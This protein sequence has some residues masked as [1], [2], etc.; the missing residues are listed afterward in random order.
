VQEGLDGRKGRPP[1]QGIAFFDCYRPAHLGFHK[2]ME[3]RHIRYFLRAVELMHFTR[4]AESLYVSQPS[5]SI[6]IRQLEEEFGA[7]LFERCRQLRLTEAGQLLFAHARA[8]VLELERAK[9]QIADLQG[10]LRGT[11]SIGFTHLFSKKLVPAVLAAYHEAHPNISLIAE[12][13]SS[14]EVEHDILTGSIDVGLAYLPPESNEIEYE[15]L[16]SDKVFLAVSHRHPFAK[17][18]EISKAELSKLPLVLQS[19]GNTMRRLVDLYFAKENI[20]PNIV[21]QLSDMPML[22]SMVKSGKAAGIASSKVIEDALFHR[23]PLPGTPIVWTA[24]ILKLRSVPL[25]AAATE[26]VK[27]VKLHSQEAL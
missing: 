14:R 4:A 10:L 1:L 13:G 22:L 27:L 5:L 19:I 6:H 18:T 2:P 11:L 3:L 23:I 15:I 25:S 17:K 20:S 9:E 24:G 16:T 21:L 7:P 12:M 26:F 8:A